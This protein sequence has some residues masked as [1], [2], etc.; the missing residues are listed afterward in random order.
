MSVFRVARRYAEAAYGLAE[1][2]KVVDAVACD[3]ELI[4]GTIAGS[5]EFVAF[6]HSPVVSK[7]KKRAVLAEL[8]QQRISGFTLS[9]LNLL[10]EKGREDVLGDVVGEFFKL[11]DERMGI[12]VLDVRAAAE[13][14]HEQQQ[15][16]IKRFASLTGKT[17]RAAFSIDRGLKGGFVAR[18]GDTVYNGSIVR[19][20][21]LLREQF[22]E[23]VARN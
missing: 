15:A 10:V 7:E 4:R 18:I 23:G 1:E 3:F 13:M 12:V 11:R 5:R 16:I 22:A 21:E 2:Q 19:Q 14:T 17:V 20:L 8:F 6:L 9:F